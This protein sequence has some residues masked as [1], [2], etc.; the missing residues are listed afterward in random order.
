MAVRIPFYEQAYNMLL[1]NDIFIDINDKY[2][3]SEY[4]IKNATDLKK[5]F[6]TNENGRTQ[7]INLLKEDKRNDFITKLPYLQAYYLLKNPDNIIDENIDN[8]ERLLADYEIYSND[9]LKLIFETNQIGRKQIIDLLKEHIKNDF[10]DRLPK[11]K[12][13]SSV[14]SIDV[15]NSNFNINNAFNMLNINTNLINNDIKSMRLLLNE[16]NIDNAN[17]LLD[18]YSSNLED[19]YRI[20]NLLNI[21]IRHRFLPNKT[22]SVNIY[23]VKMEGIKCV[24]GTTI[25]NL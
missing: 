21:N 11:Y 14:K 23:N 22:Q 17:D 1:D 16:L 19:I 13:Y 2:L 4:N 24:N 20:S 25:F 9:K 10:I 3:I 7:I 15:I 18:R 12:L 8:V 5:L 6:E